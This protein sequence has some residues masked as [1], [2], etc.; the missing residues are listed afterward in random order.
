MI[1]QLRYLTIADDETLGKA[2]VSVGGKGIMLSKI[3]PALLIKTPNSLKKAVSTRFCITKKLVSLRKNVQVENVD[4]AFTAIR[5]IARCD[6]ASCR[7]GSLPSPSLQCKDVCC[8]MS[9]KIQFSK[10]QARCY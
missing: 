4:P 10:Q 9:D 6:L 5:F 8:A 3:S 7:A 2:G 1:L